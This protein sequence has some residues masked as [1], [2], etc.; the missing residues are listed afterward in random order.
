MSD[1]PESVL[2][3]ERDF[4][5]GTQLRQLDSKQLRLWL[6]R[7]TLGQLWRKGE[8]GGTRW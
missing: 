1:R 6:K 8:I 7:Y 4:D 5:N 3:C 2:V